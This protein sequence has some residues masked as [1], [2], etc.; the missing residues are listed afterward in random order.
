MLYIWKIQLFFLIKNQSLFLLCTNLNVHETKFWDEILGRI[1][2]SS[3]ANRKLRRTWNSR[4]QQNDGGKAAESA[5]RTVAEKEDETEVR[6][7]V[8]S[9]PTTNR[10]CHISK[11]WIWICRE[12]ES[13]RRLKVYSCSLPDIGFLNKELS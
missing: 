11:T 4:N 1:T 5:E 10:W 13:V 12:K 8:V 9:H 3:G 2:R 7:T 6:R